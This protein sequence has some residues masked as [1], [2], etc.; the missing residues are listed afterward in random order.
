MDD[1]LSRAEF[2]R[3]IARASKLDAD[4]IG[5]LDLERARAIAL[6]VGIS[7]A[8]WDAALAERESAPVQAPAMHA[9]QSSASRFEFGTRAKMIGLVGLVTGALSG[10][11]GSSAGPLA[12]FLGA[13]AIGVGAGL[14]VFGA[15]RSSHR[16]TQLE[17]ATWWA[18]VFLGI[19][20][21]LQQVHT[22]PVVFAAVG[23]SISAALAYGLRRDAK[24]RTQEARGSAL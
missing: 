12:L 10:T 8:A 16:A 7:P 18:S 24:A 6:E 17:V 22:D 23:W 3:L 4:G 13:L 14:A 11:I 9:M 21:G 5:Q 19:V 2:D 20:I 15:F 1:P